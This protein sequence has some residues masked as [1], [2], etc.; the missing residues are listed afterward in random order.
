MVPGFGYHR[1]AVGMANEDRWTVLKVEDVAGGFN[2]A[3]E[4]QGLV[5]HDAHVESVR[6]QQV[7]YALPPGSV[8]KPTVDE[9]D[10]LDVGHG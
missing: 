10:V 1:S 7:V 5:L 3:L 2:V 8:D 9:N 6:R 4:R